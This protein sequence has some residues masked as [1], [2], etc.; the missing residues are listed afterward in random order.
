MGQIYL[1]NLRVRQ[2]EKIEYQGYS[3]INQLGRY[4]SLTMDDK[5]TRLY[6]SVNFINIIN[7]HL[8]NKIFPDL[9]TDFKTVFPKSNSR[10]IS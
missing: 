1:I 9:K 10:E 2:D 7:I 4:Y 5:I 3:Y 6:T 8:M